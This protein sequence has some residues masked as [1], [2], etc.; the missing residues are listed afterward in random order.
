[1][2]FQFLFKFSNSHIPLYRTVPLPSPLQALEA[3]EQEKDHLRL[4]QQNPSPLPGNQRSGSPRSDRTPTPEPQSS[5]S[6]AASS[7]DLTTTNTTSSTPPP[8]APDQDQAEDTPSINGEPEGGNA[9]VN[10]GPEPVTPSRGG[11][12]LGTPAHFKFEGPIH[13]KLE[14]LFLFFFWIEQFSYNSVVNLHDSLISLHQIQ[15]LKMM[16]W[17]HLPRQLSQLWMG[18]N[19]IQQSQRRLK[20]R[21]ASI[22]RHRR[23]VEHV[24][25]CLSILLLF[26]F[27]SFF[28]AFLSLFFG[29]MKVNTLIGDSD[30]L[31]R[32]LTDTVRSGLSSS[33]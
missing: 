22:S 28:Y 33:R 19:Q 9:P 13:L 15:F 29:F 31:S 7:P 12:Q 5:P 17:R 24:R 27:L 20:E 11:C 21:R 1:M 23:M 18:I 26:K 32:S 10:G 2:L 6:P 30:F 8:S 3:Q 4:P 16:V 14:N 25:T